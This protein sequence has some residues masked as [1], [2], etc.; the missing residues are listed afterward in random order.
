M[1]V[2][3]WLLMFLEPSLAL[4]LEQIQFLPNLYAVPWFL[5]LFAQVFDIEVVKKIWDFLFLD[6]DFI[7]LYAVSILSDLK[8]RLSLLSLTDCM[9][10]LKSLSGV[11]DYDLCLYYASELCLKIPKSFFYLNIRSQSKN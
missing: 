5:T 9:S 6:R 4:H 8:A 11:L 1:L 2:L 10:M 3:K 7:F